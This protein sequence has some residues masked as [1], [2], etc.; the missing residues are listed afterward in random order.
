MTEDEGGGGGVGYRNPAEAVVEFFSQLLVLNIT[1][2]VPFYW[3][4][5]SIQDGQ[6]TI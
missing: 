2:A 5:S 3:Y 1:Q 6:T 4:I